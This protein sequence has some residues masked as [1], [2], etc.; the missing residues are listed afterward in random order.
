MLRG[1]IIEL[2]AGIPKS[3]SWR[4][5]EYKS[6]IGKQPV[7]EAFLSKEGIMGDD[8]A[9]H[10]FHGGPD[11]A[12]CLYPFEHYAKWESE[13]GNKLILP[14]FGENITSS[15]LLESEVC[16]GDI[17]KIGEATV[18]VAQGRV[19]CSTISKFNSIESLL[20]KVYETC[21][22]G[23]FFRVLEEG[24]INR[25]SEII[26]LQSHASSITVFTAASAV[27]H[28]NADENTVRKILEVKELSDEWRQKLESI[29]AKNIMKESI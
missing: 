10:D 13:F 23:V 28:Q 26:L 1:K 24:Y 25:N 17:F 18:Q 15:G 5:K 16:I 6:A 3:H 20:G 19:P 4:G 27:L 12:L 9:N 11:R 21:L 22:T 29:M 2:S 14:A 8:V 7:D